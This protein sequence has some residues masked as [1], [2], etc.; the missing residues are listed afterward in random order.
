MEFTSSGIPASRRPALYRAP[1]TSSTTCI[2]C[3]R[4]TTLSIWGSSRTWSPSCSEL[5]PP[6]LCVY[7]WNTVHLSYV[8]M[9][10]HRTFGARPAAALNHHG[11]QR[12]EPEELVAMVRQ[13]QSTVA[14]VKTGLEE[15]HKGN[16]LYE[17]LTQVDGE[18]VQACQ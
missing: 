13:L 18:D 15:H 16:P 8:V 4:H 9:I 12:I 5:R 3:W 11:L 2:G 7:V 10:D 6:H 17:S 1:S 14:A